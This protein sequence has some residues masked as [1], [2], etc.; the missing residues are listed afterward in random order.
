M[1]WLSYLDFWHW[2]V[3]AGLMLILELWAPTYFFLW[4]G[5]AASAVGFLVLVFPTMAL[6][7]QFL[8]F[9]VLSIVAAI[10]WHR[11]RDDAP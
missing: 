7:A 4:L 2:W 8:A 10:G 3:L 9:G 5:I 1:Q 6:E 11:H